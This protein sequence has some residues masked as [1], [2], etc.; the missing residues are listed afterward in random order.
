M[1][2]ETEMNPTSL[3]TR[4]WLAARAALASAATLTITIVLPLASAE[5]LA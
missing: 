4:L 1:L 3:E 2:K 5:G